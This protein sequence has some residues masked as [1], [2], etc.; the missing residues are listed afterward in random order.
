MVSIFQDVIVTQPIKVVI[1]ASLLALVIKK[2]PQQ[3]TVI[4]VAIAKEKG[5]K[6][7]T[8]KLPDTGELLKARDYKKRVVEM[9]RTIIEI[10]FFLFFV[11]LLF[12]VCYG[13]RGSNRFVMTEG[14]EKVF[15]NFNKV[16]Q[17]QFYVWTSLRFTQG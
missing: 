12:V 8:I 9:F 7:K 2:P 15:N 4:G 1:I 10:S 14:L 13:N 16:G 17:L 11:L 3:D 6:E 5:K